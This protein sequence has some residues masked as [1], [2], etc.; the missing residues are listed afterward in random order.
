MS[1]F[2]SLLLGLFSALSFSCTF[3][4]SGWLLLSKP[5]VGVITFLLSL[6]VLIA[7]VRFGLPQFA[8]NAPSRGAAALSTLA[9]AAGVNL[10]I[11]LI[12]AG[13]ARSADIPLNWLGM[14][15]ISGAVVALTL[16]GY[17]QYLEYSKSSLL[18]EYEASV[19]EAKRLAELDAPKDAEDKFKEALLLVENC[20]GSLHLRT[21][22]S[23]L[24]LAHFYFAQEQRA[25]AAAMHRRALRTLEEVLEA[26]DLRVSSALMEWVNTDDN[27]EPEA[28]IG[29][30]RK[31]LLILERKL[32]PYAPAVAMAYDRI[33]QFL[34]LQNQLTEAENS[35]RRAYSILRKS[36]SEVARDHYRIGLRLAKCYAEMARTQEAKEILLELEE[37]HSAQRPAGQLE[38]LLTQISVY[39]ALHEGEVAQE[40]AWQALQLL[41]K[42]LGPENKS[43]KTI[44]ENCLKR[45]S[46]PYGDPESEKVLNAVFAGD[47]FQI[48][49]LL[50]A[51]PDWL[52]TRDATGWTFLQWACFFGHERLVEA[53]M[54]MGASIDEVNDEWPPF[55][56]ACRWSH[57]RLVS[58]L[59]AKL[60]T[61]EQVTREGWH[62]LHRCAENGDDRTLEVLAAQELSLEAVNSRGETPLSLACRRG[63]YR[64]VVA[65][66][67]RGGN[68]N[69]VNP[70]SGRTPLHEAAYVGHRAIAECLLLNGAKA[71]VKDRAGF[72]PMELAVQ[73]ENEALVAQLRPYTKG[74]SA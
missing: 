14:A 73:A 42:E 20:F 67:A 58:S 61:V 56:I 34:V 8:R 63:H 2:V 53:F 55:H 9:A 64:F 33:G 11:F 24:D 49:Q 69:Y 17:K 6:A 68:V 23:A 39:Q 12:Q 43:F 60:T 54:G 71:E 35:F 36:S 15:S 66:V 59:A 18:K 45:L 32:D 48:R 38:G 26:D 37:L 16:W 57:R 1:K 5:V 22:Q 13:V 70:Q 29:H 40:K 46:T 44:W 41:Q 31:A 52:Q 19:T 30:L 74:L 72:T 47:S 10:F 3:L 65:K 27:L 25:K 4:G 50:G 7:I 51:H 62:A 28:A 21:A